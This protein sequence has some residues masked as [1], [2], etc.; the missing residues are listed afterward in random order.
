MSRSFSADPTGH[1]SH[2]VARN[3]NIVSD[4]AREPHCLQGLDKHMNNK[5]VDLLMLLD[6]GS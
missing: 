6:N 5:R 4:F 3:F 2:L 1:F